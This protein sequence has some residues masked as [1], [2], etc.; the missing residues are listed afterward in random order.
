VAGRANQTGTHQPVAGRANST[1][2]HEPVGGRA[3]R[4]GTHQPVGEQTGGH[5]PA[6]AVRHAPVEPEGRPGRRSVERREGERREVEPQATAAIGRRRATEAAEAGG[7]RRAEDRHDTWEEI[8]KPSRRKAAEPAEP[9]G[10]HADGKSVSELLAAFGGADSPRRR[11]R[12][13]ED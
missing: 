10:A 5:R 4:T 2:T 8:S 11:R 6:D 7:R 13:G 9:A 1:G 3:S 12:R